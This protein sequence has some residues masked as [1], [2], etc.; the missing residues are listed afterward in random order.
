VEAKLMAICMGFMSI[1]DNKV[2]HIIVIADS[3]VAGQKIISS[4][5]QPL[6]KSIIPIAMKIKAFLERD[7]CNSIQFW[8][9][10]S[11]LKW[12]KHTLVDEEAK[13]THTSPSFLEKNSFLFSKKKE[14]N[15]LLETW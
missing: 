5:D 1:L 7:S 3:L 4:G 15:F 10:P 12:P 6:Q 11:K 2:Q 14:C 13:A 9:C 8:Y